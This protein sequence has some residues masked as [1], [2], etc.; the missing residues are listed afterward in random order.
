MIH[1]RRLLC[2]AAAL[3]FPAIAQASN[4]VTGLWLDEDKLG[5]IQLVEQGG[6]LQGYIAGSVN[7]SVKEDVKNPDNA[8][9]GKNLLH[10][11]IIQNLKFDG[12]VWTGG[13]IY[14]PNDGN[15]YSVTIT[16]GDGNTLYLRGFLGL[17][18]FGMTQTWTRV[19]DKKSPGLQPL[20]KQSQG[21]D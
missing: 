12:K 3:L 14:N 13:T 19:T 7:G 6:I 9:R 10:K 21:A 16:P 2:V 17:P 4:P 8:Q 15:T 18:M 20:P 1:F 5:Y 11:P